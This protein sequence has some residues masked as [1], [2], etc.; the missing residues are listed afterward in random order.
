MYGLKN[1]RHRWSDELS[2]VSWGQLEQLLAVHYQSQGFR[3]EHCGTGGAAARFDGG[4]DLKLFR[5]D[6]YI[7][8]QCK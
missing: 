3:V 6:E 8:V 1:V 4:I 5:D 7:V 2:R